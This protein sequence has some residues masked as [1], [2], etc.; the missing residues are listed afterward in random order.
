MATF[1]GQRNSLFLCLSSVKECV[2]KRVNHFTSGNAD[3]GEEN[4]EHED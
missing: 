3:S 2:C 1:E 4:I